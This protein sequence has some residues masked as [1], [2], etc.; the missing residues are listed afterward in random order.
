MSRREH[1]ALNDKYFGMPARAKASAIQAA[2]DIQDGFPHFL[3]GDVLIVVTSS[4]RYKLH[5]DILRRSSPTF[6]ALLDKDAAVDLSK[7]AKKKGVTVRWRLHVVQNNNGGVRKDGIE[8]P[9]HVLR[10]IPLDDTG[11]VVGEFPALLGDANENGR[12]I[13][14]W[15]L[16]SPR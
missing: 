10:R 13:P 4:R 16:V 6:M 1:Y 15:V 2:P 8:T 11:A 3:D 9:A 5:S 12:M 14:Q 7:Y